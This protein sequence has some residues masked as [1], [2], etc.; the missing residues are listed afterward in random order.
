MTPKDVVDKVMGPSIP[1]K[2]SKRNTKSKLKLAPDQVDLDREFE[3]LMV[4]PCKSFSNLW[5]SRSIPTELRCKLRSVD[6]SVKQHMLKN[7]S[8]LS[9]SPTKTSPTKS[10]FKM[11]STADLHS[12]PKKAKKY[13]TIAAASTAAAT[14]PV[15]AHPAAIFTEG[16][17][18]NMEM[19]SV[20]DI[21]TYF[22][23]IN[24]KEIDVGMVKKL[25]QLLRN[26]SIMYRPLW[27][28]KG[29]LM[30]DGSRS[31]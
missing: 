28:D 9:S 31:F 8:S 15:K 30:I 7:H 10:L 27:R 25:W 13:S 1:N 17:V 14:T 20:V 16:R 2:L 11:G 18:W 3:E 19:Q 26:E 22:T 24:V 29:G 5:N 21:K 4:R 6:A 12:S 23:G